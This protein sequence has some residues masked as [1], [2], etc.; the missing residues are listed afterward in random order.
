MLAGFI[1]NKT[2]SYTGVFPYVAALALVGLVVAVATLKP[3]V[4]RSRTGGA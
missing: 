2:G 3:P 1:R 4:A